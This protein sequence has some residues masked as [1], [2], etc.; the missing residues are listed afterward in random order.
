MR[1]LHLVLA[2]CWLCAAAGALDAGSVTE[3]STAPVAVPDPGEVAAAIDLSESLNIA[4]V[5][6]SVEITHPFIGDLGL[7]IESPAG[8]LVVVFAGDGEDSADMLVTF[9]DDGA[10]FD[11][12]LLTCDCEM[13]PGF[14]NQLAS[15]G[16][17]ESAGEWELLLFDNY[18][19]YAGTLEEWCLLI[20]GCGQAPA[21]GI[22]CEAD[23]SSVT[24]SWSN[25]EPAD[26][27]ALYRNSDL[28]ADL[29]PESTTYEDTDLAP[30][31]YLYR[32]LS[33]DD[34]EDCDSASALCDATVG[35]FEYCATPATGNLISFFEEPVTSTV[36]VKEEFDVVDVQASVE[37]THT[38]IGDLT[39]ALAS[40]DATEITLH[41]H[42]GD[43]QARILATFSSV[44]SEPGTVLYNCNCRI[45][46]AGPGTFADFAGGAAAGAWT[47]EVSDDFDLDNGELESWCLGAMGAVEEPEGFV[48]LRGDATGNG[49]FSALLDALHI[50]TY[51]FSSGP[52]PPCLAAADANGDG[53]VSGLLDGLYLLTHGFSGGPAPPAPYPDCGPAPPT[54]LSCEMEP[55]CE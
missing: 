19:D 33:H 50:L 3:C 12:A 18:S 28:V 14:E 20:E 17:E 44:G 54:E 45:L 13:K 49:L 40:P 30:G 2:A 16:E 15:F 7:G 22:S 10:D 36:D 29:A 41:D 9:A 47:L 39:I 34:G 5:A 25:P 52:A 43:S 21:T 8:T 46:P 37:I 48:F 4:E 24:L 35:L 51:A 42:G 53:S 1:I 23:G 32:L 31:V 27:L 11:P 38:F 26:A 55:E 6:V